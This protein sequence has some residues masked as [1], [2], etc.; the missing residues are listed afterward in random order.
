M[1]FLDFNIK[2]NR[3][4]KLANTQKGHIFTYFAESSFSNSSQNY[5][6]IEIDWKKKKVN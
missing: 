3:E 2:Q 5:E 4:T 6:V 1:H